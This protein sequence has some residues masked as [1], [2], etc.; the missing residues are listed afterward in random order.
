MDEIVISTERAGPLRV[1]LARERR[2]VVE[3]ASLSLALSREEAWQLAEAIDAV[4][5]TGDA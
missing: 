1:R 5:T 4:A 2:V 3:G